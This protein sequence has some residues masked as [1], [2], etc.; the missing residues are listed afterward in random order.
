MHDLGFEATQKNP[1]ERV[2][3]PCEA[4]EAH[5]VPV[6]NRL[7]ENHNG[8]DVS[9]YAFASSTRKTAREL[10]P[11]TAGRSDTAGNA[12]ARGGTPDGLYRLG[13]NMG[14]LVVKTLLRI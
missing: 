4:G 2:C 12:E 8:L 5:R 13:M 10:G 14:V 7:S 9:R 11:R 3:T 6:D 1:T